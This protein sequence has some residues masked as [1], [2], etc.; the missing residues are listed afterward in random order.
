MPFSLRSL[1]VGQLQTNCYLLS[2]PESNKGVIIDPGD[3]ADYIQRL[4]QDEGFQPQQIIATHG[5]F[6]HLMAAYE[7][8]HAYNLPFIIHPKDKFLVKR[9]SQTAHHFL[10]IIP[11]PPPRIDSY[12]KPNQKINLAGLS[13]QIIPTPGHT[14]GS[15]SLYHQKHKLLFVGDLLFAGGAV[16]R[17]D[18]SYSNPQDLNRSIKKIL[19]LPGQTQV[20]PGHGLP[21]TIAKEKAHFK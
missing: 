15:V 1:S 5:H 18:F 6:D 3:D 16:G 8:Q 20:Y 17:T 12:L 7:L 19:Q 21:T 13:F 14:P 10:G 11:G 2:N 9:M 4:I